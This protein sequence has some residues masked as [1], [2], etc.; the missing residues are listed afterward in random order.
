MQCH[1]KIVSPIFCSLLPSYIYL[2]VFIFTARI[3][4]NRKNGSLIFS[5]VVSSDAGIYECQLFNEREI[6][7][8]TKKSEL[9]VIEQLKFVPQPTSKNLELS[10]VAK[11]HCKVQGTPTPKVKWTKV[12]LFF[13]FFFCCISEAY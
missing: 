10:T 11:I 4:V 8:S 9:K 12:I 3:L 5:T 2:S 7:M 1:V 6:Q 13:S